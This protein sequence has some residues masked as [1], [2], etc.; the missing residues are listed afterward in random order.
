MNGRER[1]HER[2]VLVLLVQVLEH[3]PALPEDDLQA[4]CALMVFPVLREVVAQ[5]FDSAAPNRDLCLGGPR[6]LLIATEL[7]HDRGIKCRFT[8]RVPARTATVW[9]TRTHTHATRVYNQSFALS[10]HVLYNGVSFRGSGCECTY[11]TI[12]APLSLATL[13]ARAPVA[14]GARPP[15][16]TLLAVALQAAA[17]LHT[18]ALTVVA[19]A[20]DAV[21]D[22]VAVMARVFPLI[23]III[24]PLPLPLSLSLS[25]S[26]AR[27][28][29]LFFFETHIEHFIM[30]SL[31]YKSIC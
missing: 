11:T 19:D 31:L 6:I 15:C 18:E 1:A 8:V 23:I 7:G 3:L 28:Y 30:F 17:L 10:P 29:P 24:S 22:G 14:T 26:F 25:L 27:R 21:V 4:P 5:L 13:A 9:D 20:R 16:P 2:H 12:S